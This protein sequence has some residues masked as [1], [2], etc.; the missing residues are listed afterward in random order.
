MGTGEP[1][2]TWRLHVQYSTST[3]RRTSSSAGPGRSQQLEILPSLNS[4]DFFSGPPTFPAAPTFSWTLTFWQAPQILG[5]PCF[6]HPPGFWHAPCF[7][8]LPGFW[9]APCF[10]HP[11]GFW[12]AP[13][14]YHPPGFC[15]APLFLYIFQHFFNECA[16]N[17]IGANIF[18]LLG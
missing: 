16:N 9:N 15:Q 7:Y 13:C 6:Y 4:K 14:F 8:H 18:R 17:L 5:P 3:R 12:H 2:L 1:F 11:P 10:Y